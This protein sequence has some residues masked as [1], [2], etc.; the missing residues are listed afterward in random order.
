M[1]EVERGLGAGAYA[2]CVSG[3]RVSVFMHV[4]LAVVN[5]GLLEEPEPQWPRA[6]G[7]P[8]LNAPAGF[9]VHGCSWPERPLAAALCCVFVCVQ[10]RIRG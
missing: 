1:K 2:H 9:C 4:P 8:S 10:Q 6:E 5:Y 7:I 3:V